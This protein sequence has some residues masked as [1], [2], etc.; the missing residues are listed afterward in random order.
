M[1]SFRGLGVA[2]GPGFFESESTLFR[3][4]GVGFGVLGPKP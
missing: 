4:S 1:T 2:F 3:V